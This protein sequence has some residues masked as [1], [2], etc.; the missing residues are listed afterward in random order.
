M[1][2]I[3]KELGEVVAALENVTD[4]SYLERLANGQVIASQCVEFIRTRH[5]ALAAMVADA[6]RYRWIRKLAADGGQE[7]FAPV[8]DAAFAA[9][10]NDPL[11]FDYNI[12]LFMRKDTARQ[13]AGEVG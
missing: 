1:S 8:E 12:D 3:A 2:E 9:C 5:A 6:E 7:N 10:Y 11:Q 13:A 4:G